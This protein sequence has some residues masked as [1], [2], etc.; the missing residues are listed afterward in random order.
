MSNCQACLSLSQVFKI[1]CSIFELSKT[2][3]KF[4]G[5][6]FGIF[7]VI[8]A[9]DVILH[10]LDARDPLGTRSVLVEK[11]VDASPGK[12]LVYILNKAGK[13]FGTIC[14]HICLRLIDSPQT[15]MTD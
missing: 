7:Q 9:A 6:I 8:E 3:S 2:G 4:N 11:S 5:N 1:T 13:L 14:L 15:Y 12:R 10:V